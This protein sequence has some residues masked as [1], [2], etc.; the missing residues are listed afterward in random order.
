M[1]VLELKQD[2]SC[3]PEQAWR[4]LTDPDQ[5]NRWSSAKIVGN[6][7]GV[8]DRYD[9]AGALRKVITPAPIRSVL[10][11]VV[12]A[13]RQPESFEYRV[14]AGPATVRHHQGRIG[15]VEASGGCTVT[16]TVEMDFVA[17]GIGALVE[18]GLRNELGKSLRE[19]AEQA[20]LAQQA[21][22]PPEPMPEMVGRNH[23]LV[24]LKSLRAKAISTLA[25]QQSMAGELRDAGDPKQW[26]ARV[27]AIVTEEMIALVDGGAL[28]YPDWA[29][30]LIPD[31]HVHYATNLQGYRRGETIERPW[32]VAWSRCEQTD[33]GRPIL[34]IVSGMLAGV[35][36]HIESDLPRSLAGV[37]SKHYRDTHHYKDFRSDYL[38]MADVFGVASD[39]LL[40]Q[41]PLSYK[42]LW[43]RASVRLPAEMR[44][45][46]LNRRTFD[47]PKYR[48]AA[49]GYGYEIVQ[50]VGDGVGDPLH[51]TQ[52]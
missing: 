44:S 40:Q 13:A 43:V 25:E 52:G 2:L 41:M 34:P 18:R 38:A 1:R 49:F 11:E 45:A 19:L 48:L 26:F 32:Q 31:F 16:W 5:M 9:R 27:Y 37:Y 23:G 3:T 33:S 50:S 10:R 20:E 30:R 6:D 15:I 14:Y 21:Q 47:I 8:D 24:D 39:R 17:P 36:A 29:L 12:V 42:P 28:Q 22:G 4:L 35:R 46:L 7:P 51:P